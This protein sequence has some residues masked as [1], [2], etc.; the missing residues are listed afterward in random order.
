MADDNERTTV[1][2]PP[3][4]LKI[5]AVLVVLSLLVTQYLIWIQP[6]LEAWFLDSEEQEPENPEEKFDPDY[7]SQV[8][9]RWFDP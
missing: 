8:R 3:L 1:F 6:L 2:F 9:R 5:L 4:V 7:D